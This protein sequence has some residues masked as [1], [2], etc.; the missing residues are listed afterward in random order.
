MDNGLFWLPN[1]MFKLEAG[2]NYETG[3]TLTSRLIN[4]VFHIWIPQPIYKQEVAGDWPSFWW[5]PPVRGPSPASIACFP[6]LPYACCYLHILLKSLCPQFCPSDIH[7]WEHM[8]QRPSIALYIG[9]A[10]YILLYS[11]C[12]SL[13]FYYCYYS[14][15]LLFFTVLPFHPTSLSFFS[16]PSPWKGMV[17]EQLSAL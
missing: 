4:Q 14:I 8:L 5:L 12:Y 6:W 9:I 3:P 10:L 16:L 2:R 13:F 7:C 17:R 15:L 11:H 1:C